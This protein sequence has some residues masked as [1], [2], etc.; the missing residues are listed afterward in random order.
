VGITLT[1]SLLMIPQKSVSAMVGI[2]AGGCESKWHD[3]TL[4]DKSDCPFRM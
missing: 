1:Q 3:C 4:C 2:G